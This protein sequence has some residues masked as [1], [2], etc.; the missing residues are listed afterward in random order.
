MSVLNFEWFPK[1]SCICD[2]DIV[3]IKNI[4]NH[5]SAPVVIYPVMYHELRLC[6]HKNDN[7]VD[8][9]D[10]HDFIQILKLYIE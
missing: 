4:L 5:R 7:K 6:L 1:S 2:K 9:K 10:H 8:R 3:I